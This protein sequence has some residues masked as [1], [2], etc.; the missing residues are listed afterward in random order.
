[1]DNNEKLKKLQLICTDILFYFDD[2]CKK[3]GLRYYLAYG[4]LLGT[5]RHKG[6]IPWDDDV[7]LYMPRKDLEL[8]LNEFS[9]DIK[10]PYRINHYTSKYFMSNSFNLRIGSQKAQIKRVIGGEAKSIDVWIS[11]FPIDDAPQS[12]FL[13]K[14]LDW[15]ST[16]DYM[17]LRMVRSANNGLGDVD[18]SFKEKVGVFI[19]K[20]LPFFKG[21]SERVMAHRMNNTLSRYRGVESDYKAV[22]SYNVDPLYYKSKWFGQ[23]VYLEFEGR[24]LPCPSGYDEILRFCYGDYMQLPPLEKQKPAHGIDVVFVD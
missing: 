5:V 10:E 19:N 3:R 7:D 2:L 14:I 13:R 15:K 6:F 4:T 16:F 12:A 1:M 8:L 20:M 21:K 24:K 17:C 18:R 23:P 11:V 22:F 9:E